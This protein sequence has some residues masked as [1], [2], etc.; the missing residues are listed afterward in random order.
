MANSNGSQDVGAW[1]ATATCLF[2][3]ASRPGNTRGS[4]QQNALGRYDDNGGVWEWTSDQCCRKWAGAGR[5]PERSTLETRS[6][7]REIRS[8]SNEA[9]KEMPQ[10]RIAVQSCCYYQ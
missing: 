8:T 10:A 6:D 9:D 4:T 5:A 7:Q 2:S 3:L 1:E